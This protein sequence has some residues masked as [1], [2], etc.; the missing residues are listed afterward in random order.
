MNYAKS[1]FFNF[2]IVFFANHILPGISVNGI[3]KIPHIKSDLLFP[4]CLG[5]MNSLI[6]PILR[7]FGPS[8]SW[9]RMGALALILNFVAYA[10][11]KI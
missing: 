10:I 2:L 11:L 4:L 7:I 3:T 6:Y 8:V 9:F 1:L 5:L